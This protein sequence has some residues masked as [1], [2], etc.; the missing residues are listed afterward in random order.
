MPEKQK[1]E[2]DFVTL[3]EQGNKQLNLHVLMKILIQQCMGKSIDYARV[4]GMS[5]RSFQ[6]FERLVK[7]DFYK[8]IDYSHKI[9]TEH[10]FTNDAK[11]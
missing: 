11:K 2:H 1:S 8:I 5:D 6:Q 7:D 3:D 9:L 4:S 10:N